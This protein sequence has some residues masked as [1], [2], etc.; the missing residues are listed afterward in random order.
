MDKELEDEKGL[1]EK[2]VKKKSIK[3]A[4]E[5]EILNKNAIEINPKMNEAPMR[6]VVLGWGRM[7][8]ITSGHELLVNKIKEV[9]KKNRATPV[10]YI[11]HSQ[12]A[13]K[14][15]LS[16]EDKVMLAKRAFGN[17]IQKSNSKTIMQIMKELEDRFDKVI[18]VAGDDRVAEFSKLLNKYNG[19]E[20]NISEIE[21]VSAGKRADPDSD[22]AKDMSAANMSASVMRKLASEG[23]LA[24]FKKGLPKRLQ[25]DAQD[26]YDLVRSGMKLAEMAEEDGQLTEAM[27]IQ[28]RRARSLIMRKF[29]VKIASARRRLRKKAATMDKLKIRA[30]K[31]A[32]RIIRKR[33]AGKKGEDYNNLSPSEKMLVDKRV[34]KKRGAIDKIAKR[35]LPMVRKADL[36][37]LRSKSESV[38]ADFE[39]FLSE[40][41]VN[42]AFDMFLEAETE[43][44]KYTKRYHQM[45]SKEGTIK[46]DGRFR[47]FRAKKEEEESLK[48]GSALDAV[49][50]KHKDERIALQKRHKNEK[51]D[52][53]VRE[54][55]A[56]AQEEFQSDLDLLRFIEETSNDIFNAVLLDEEKS[57]EGL[58]GKAE[59]SGI[60]YGI[61][62][63][64]FDRGLAAYQTSHRPGTTPQQW[65]Y[66]RVNSFITG[67][68]T[69]TTGDADLWA[70]HSGVKESLDEDFKNMFSE[71]S[72]SDIVKAVFSSIAHKKQY[73]H[74]IKTLMSLL[75]RKKKEA[76]SKSMK[77]STSYYAMQ[78]ARSYENVDSRTLEKM[79]PKEYVSEEGGA[80]DRGTDKLT[81][82]YKKDTPG[83]N[84]T[85]EVTQ[86]QLN[87]LEKF[88]DR[89]LAKFKI[90]VE[91]TRH[92]ADRM[93]DDRNKPAIT[94]PE[95]QRVFKKIASHK[96]IEIR[97]NPDIEAV[98]K[99]IQTDLNLPIVINYDKNKDEFEVVN[100]TIMRKKNFGTT[101]KVINV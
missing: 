16:Y 56:V 50:D 30:R 11:S 35:L 8:P 40:A 91:F 96:G 20:Y 71:R 41:T 58:K 43:V 32:I 4:S 75:D 98:L 63:K 99:D 89:L 83:Q 47:A 87:D 100:K 27:T 88:A 81:K 73:D 25:A 66:A 23:D 48:E 70:K 12:D 82:R 54:I 6:T 52:V 45:Y 34:E 72:P 67:G 94:I 3:K 84:V 28:Q 65:A 22:A 37:K 26:V 24:G 69:R 78:I 18:L 55:R 14:N 60:S 86:Q 80:G 38:D 57:D 31:A 10:I 62:K 29:K 93:N 42:E 9:A 2:P 21:V 5:D 85:E 61:L 36:L 33:I 13:K 76:G 53:R 1:E 15:P 74:A 101:S 97:Q 64:V 77:H 90:D 17:I 46:L 59:K 7:N 51:A 44:S 19:S 49:I 68:K 92:F 95:L 79:L 39:N